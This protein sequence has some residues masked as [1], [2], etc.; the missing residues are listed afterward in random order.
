MEA[1]FTI[2]FLLGLVAA[3]AFWL[4]ALVDVIRHPGDSYRRGT[5]VVWAVVI[6]LTHSLGAGAYVLFGRPRP[7]R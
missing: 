7:A 2:V 6:A 4:W 1:S 3:T 5:Q